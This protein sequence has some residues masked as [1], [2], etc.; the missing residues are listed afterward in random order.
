MD[1]YRRACF[2]LSFVLSCLAQPDFNLLANVTSTEDFARFIMKDG[3]RINFSELLNTDE[4]RQVVGGTD[5]TEPAK[6]APYD[7][8]SPR[9][10]TVVIPRD[11]DPSI[12]YFPPCTRVKRCGGCAPAE[13]LACEPKLT[14]VMSVLVVRSRIPYPGSPDTQFEAFETKQIIKHESCEP[15]C[16]VKPHHCNPLQ[17][18]IARDCSCMCRDRPACPTDRH[19][20]DEDTCM[21]KCSQR[22][23]NCPGFSRFSDKTCRCE[24]RQGVSGMSDEEIRNLLVLASQVTTTTTTTTPAPTA[25]PTLPPLVINIPNSPC[26]PPFP[27]PVG[28]T[29]KISV[30]NGRCQCM[31]PQFRLPTLRGRRQAQL[32]RR[33][34]RNQ[35][36][37]V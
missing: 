3:H 19:I 32:S 15:Q 28:M 10:Q 22:N 9:F 37:H 27:C 29:P 33:L 34:L 18:Y 20:W 1:I 13:V 12:V 6:L 5:G 25:P 17:A 4:W 2:L 16:K 30:I 14:S 7:Y 26:Q 36:G 8:C 11:S 21:C 24:L 23:D 35:R 31:L